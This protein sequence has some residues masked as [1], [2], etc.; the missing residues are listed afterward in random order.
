MLT[1]P[2]ENIVYI[3]KLQVRLKA[4]CE[5]YIFQEESFQDRIVLA[6]AWNYK[7]G[8]GISVSPYD[9]FFFQFGDLLFG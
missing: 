6:A 2:T 1:S 7:S 5:K 9:L 3:R 4:S 8:P